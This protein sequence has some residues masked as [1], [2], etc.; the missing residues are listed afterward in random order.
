MTPFISPSAP[1]PAARGRPHPSLRLALSMAA[2]L[3]LHACGGGS[4]DSQDGASS[5]AGGSAGSTAPRPGAADPRDTALDAALASGDASALTDPAFVATRLRVRMQFVAAAQDARLKSLL[6]GVSSEYQPGAQSHWVQPANIEL[7]QPYIV[8]DKG[9]QLA[10]LSLA[11]GGR[12][13]GY[14]VQVLEQLRSGSNLAHAPA[15]ARLVRWLVTGSADAS[16]PASLPVSFAGLDAARSLAGLQAAGVPASNAGC[17]ALDDAACARTA[18]LLVLGSGL[19]ASDTLEATVRSRLAAGLPVLYLHG[20]AWSDSDSGRQVLSAMALTFGPYGGNYWDKD[21]VAPGRSAAAAAQAASQF[22]TLLPLAA[23]AATNTWRQDF[24]WSRCTSSVGTTE[25]SAVPG[26]SA[27]NAGVESLRAAV[28]GFNSAGRNVFATADTTLLR[29]WLLWADSVRRE[30]RYPL[31]KAGDAAL[32]QRAY[33]ADALVGYVR[34]RGTAQPDLGSYAG[35][36]QA[37]MKPSATEETIT[38]KLP[39]SGGFTAIG[40][41]AVPGRP[42]R[43]TLVDAG[44]ASVA[45]ALNTMRTGSTKTWNPRSY[46][47]PRFLQSPGMPLAKGRALPV[48][49]PYGGTLQLHYSQAAA[50][51]T[52]TLRVQGAARHPFFDATAGG[53]LAAARQAFI[54]ALDAGDADWAEMKMQGVEIHSRIDKMRSV[55]VDAYANDLERYLQEMAELFIYDAYQLAGF[56]LPNRP[57]PAAVLQACQAR[58]WDCTSASL[59]GL[60][61]VQHINA[62]AYAHC[63]AGCSGN[64]YDQSWGVT[65]RGW[66]ESHE[67]GHNLQVGALNVYGGRSSEVS[68]NIFPLHKNWRLKRE[69][70]DT[71]DDTRVSYREAFDLILAGRGQADPVQG[72]Y[73]RIWADDG[74]AVQNGIRLAFYLQWVHY[75]AERQGNEARGWD[76]WTLLYLHQR[77]ASRSDWAANKASLGF[78][79]F[80]ERPSLDGNDHLLIALS[81]LTQRDQRPVF[82]LWGLRTSAAAQAQVQAYGFAAERAFFY[83]NTSTNDH[84]KVRRV[85]MGVAQPAWPF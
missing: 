49:S 11:E 30:I 39:N 8:G 31:D 44:G 54:R 48:V 37:A 68:N 41:M 26:L 1:T 46:N 34:E 43:V 62:D 5:H 23:Q 64:P 20:N 75:W 85:D 77:L 80:G 16:L 10:S 71:R 56:A 45:L 42:L 3:L 33:L 36:A 74:Y 65:P 53:D 29:L 28:N 32:F 6:E 61:Q 22:N 24:D 21:A 76:I 27:W 59:H 19:V 9:R 18:R 47:R 60:T 81:W 72:V 35:A 55:I 82:A 4:S 15:L 51:Q 84:A 7:A 83:A 14:G 52:V 40:R 58:G 70:G 57:L 69:L 50:G 17:N 67:V 2:L 78:S 63:G 25:C 79:T 13:A 12:S 73:D 66:G 38:L